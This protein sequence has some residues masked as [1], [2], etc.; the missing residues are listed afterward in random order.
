[1]EQEPLRTTKEKGV[2]DNITTN[3]RKVLYDLVKW[4][5]DMRLE[6]IN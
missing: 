2:Q 5:R 6:K 3:R 1:M 4:N